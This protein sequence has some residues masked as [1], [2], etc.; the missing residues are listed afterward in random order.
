M[1]LPKV[2]QQELRLSNP[3]HLLKKQSSHLQVANKIND[4][5]QIGF[6]ITGKPHI[7]DSL[8]LNS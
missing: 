4:M 7:T 3:I 1:K 6:K 2:S 8:I 5:K